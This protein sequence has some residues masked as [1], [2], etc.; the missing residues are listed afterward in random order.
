VALSPA[1]ALP[2]VVLSGAIAG[3]LGAYLVTFPEPASLTLIPIVITRG[4]VENS[5][6]GLSGAWVL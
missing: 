4:I 5:G 6:V 1:S 3:V 2:T